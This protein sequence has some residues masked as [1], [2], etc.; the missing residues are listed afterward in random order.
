MRIA[1]A[2]PA[3]PAGDH[4]AC[5]GAGCHDRGGAAPVFDDCAGCHQPDLLADHERERRTRRWS[6]RATFRHASHQEDPRDGSALDCRACHTQI[7]QATALDDLPPPAKATC[8][9][10]HDGA[11]A[12]KLTGH[13]CSRCHGEVATTS[14]AE[15]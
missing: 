2:S 15:P 8:A 14:A 4:R 12:F 3:R 6:A 7:L 5:A 10:C 9:P 11:I 13:A 1:S